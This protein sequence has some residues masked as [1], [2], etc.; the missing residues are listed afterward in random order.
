MW[1][2]P[3][4]T[5]R[6]TRTH[7]TSRTESAGS[8]SAIMRYPIFNANISVLMHGLEDNPILKIGPNSNHQVLYFFGARHTNNNND[9]QFGRLKKFWDEFLNNSSEERVAIIE[10]N[11]RDVPDNY[12]E[13]IKKYGESG[14]IFW[15][16]NKAS[17]PVVCAEPSS[18]EQRKFL[19]SLFDPQ[20]VAYALIVQNLGAWFRH[21][22]DSTFSQA[23]ERSIKREAEF[24]GIYEFI[25]D[26]NWLH[27][28][29]NE[30]FDQ[31]SLEDE[32]FLNSISDPRKDDTIIN[33]IISNGTEMRNN[34]IK[35]VI[36]ENWKDKKSIFIVYGKGHL[37]ILRDSLKELTSM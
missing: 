19:C 26:S 16:A 27:D 12:E 2:A 20:L 7:A 30:L 3:T 13:A 5:T 28:K 8:G 9:V 36:V 11:V 29:H 37:S 4:T 33:A 24:T 22:R 21:V 23:V 32:K 15:L 25:P 35:S 17:I 34:H 6:T 31:Q 14:A 18:S 10:G 1:T